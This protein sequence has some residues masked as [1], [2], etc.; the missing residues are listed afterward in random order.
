MSERNKAL[1]RRL[2]EEVYGR[3][4]IATADEIVA[5]DF[6]GHATT[7]GEADAGVEQF[8]Q[9]VQELRQAFPDL[10]IS[11]EDQIAEGDRV[12]T[13]WSVTGTHRGAFQG[14]GP[15][16][17]RGA[18]T[19]ISIDRYAN[20]KLVECWENSDDLGLLQQLG[21]VPAPAATT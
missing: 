10:H 20:G 15:T 11:I 3:G 18:M 13:R 9:F 12:V 19:G 6:V 2:I 7:I 1:S 21:V 4:N 16:G 14:I 17:A 8:K 5:P